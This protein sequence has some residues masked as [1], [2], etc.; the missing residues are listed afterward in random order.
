MDW[1]ETMMKFCRY[2]RCVYYGQKRH[3]STGR[4]CYY[5]EPGCILGYLD[6]LIEIFRIWWRLRR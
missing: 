4:K 2:E 5:G 1:E 6:M 3:P